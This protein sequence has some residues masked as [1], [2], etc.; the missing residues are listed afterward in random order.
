MTKNERINVLVTGV[1]GG[2]FGRQI[3]K[4]LK[5][6]SIPYTIIGTDIS[7]LSI[8]L[9]E[10][11]KSYIV[12][13]A[14]AANYIPSV[15]DICCKENIDVLIAGSEPELLKIS[16]NRAEFEKH[17]IFLLLNTPDVLKICMNKWE[18]YN[19]L[20]M[21]G[22]DCPK[23][24]LID[25][26]TELSSIDIET[27]VG[28][29]LIVKPSLSSS[30][31]SNVFIA[32][33]KEELEFFIR[34]LRKQWLTP[35]VQKYI[36]S[37]EEEYTIGILT[38]MQTGRLISSIAMKRHILSGLSNKI[39][40]KNRNLDVLKTET[41]VISSGIS[42]G[43]IDDFPMVRRYCEDIALKLRSKGPLNIQCRKVGNKILTFEIN[44]RF[45]GT[46]SIRALV[47]FNEPDI[48]I[49]KC[50]LYE[51]ISPVKYKKGIVVRGLSELYIPFDKLV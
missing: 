46:T 29:P 39:N 13:Q 24:L 6:A 21:N 27:S 20:L 19:F 11:D 12:P 33:D 50:V 5:M 40:V 35:I 10:V 2:G 47:G 34:Y 8:G 31:S 45:S 44:P 7:P 49:R 18:T 16:E 42:Q 51:A 15:L 14:N 4:A 48:L 36:G 23:S 30:G 22:F 38:D 17:R 41:L 43:I 1:G 37:F 25:N 3:L 32:Q 9:Y 26:T 28:F